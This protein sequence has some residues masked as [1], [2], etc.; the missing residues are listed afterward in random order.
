[1][2]CPGCHKENPETSRFCAECGTQLLP[3]KELPS[4]PKIELKTPVSVLAKGGTF[5][6]KYRIIEELGRG[7]MGIVCEAEDTKLERTVALKFLP[8]ELTKDPQAKAR[9]RSA[10][11]IPTPCSG[12][13][14]W[15]P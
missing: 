12:S 3:S 5:V 7:G 10:L 9:C 4:S 8:P 6:G 1:M 15:S 2:K 14:R 13:C 11:T